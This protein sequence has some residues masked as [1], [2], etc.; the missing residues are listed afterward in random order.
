MSISESDLLHFLTNLPIYVSHLFL[1]LRNLFW[2]PLTSLLKR[3]S[4]FLM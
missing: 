4:Y 2:N 1:R 3:Q